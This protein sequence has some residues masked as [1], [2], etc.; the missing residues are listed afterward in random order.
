[1]ERGRR[2]SAHGVSARA[3][4][5]TQVYAPLIVAPVRHATEEDTAAMHWTGEPGVSQPRFV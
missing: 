3:P 4:E 2:S 1:M 5:A